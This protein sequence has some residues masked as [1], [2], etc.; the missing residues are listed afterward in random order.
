MN[1]S[2]DNSGIFDD[3]RKESIRNP[4]TG[5]RRCFMTGK[6]CIFRPEGEHL[7]DTSSGS[8]VFVVMPFR[9]HLD[10]FYEWSL[11]PF[12]VNQGKSPKSIRRADQIS[13]T[14]YV[15]CESICRHIQHAKLVFVKLAQSL[16]RCRDR[17]VRRLLLRPGST[18]AGAQEK[19]K[20]NS[21]GKSC[22]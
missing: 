12:L 1:R 3:R 14:G 21:A 19:P 17:R 20:Q 9:P 22:G 15:M 7:Q 4:A 8:D 16:R 6:R 11:K 18:A 10:T 13:R 5:M 2:H